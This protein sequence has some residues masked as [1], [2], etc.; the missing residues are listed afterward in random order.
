MEDNRRFKTQ[1]S[2]GPLDE[3]SCAAHWLAW[4]AK[5]K[6]SVPGLCQSTFLKGSLYSQ[7]I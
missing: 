7:N 3:C 6:K 2:A 4:L 1:K 5:K